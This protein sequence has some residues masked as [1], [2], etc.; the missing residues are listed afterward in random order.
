[1]Q[2]L[3]AE[4]SVEEACER[5]GI[6]RAY[7]QELR[8]RALQGALHALRPRSPGRPAKEEPMDQAELMHLRQEKAE[9]EEELAAM[10]VRMEVLLTM[11][12]LLRPP[13]KTAPRERRKQQ[14][15]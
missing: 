6:E 4:L 3:T 10:R 8:E 1:M 5:L 13:K 12:E 2:T 14:P 11:P 7:F 9:L 15:G